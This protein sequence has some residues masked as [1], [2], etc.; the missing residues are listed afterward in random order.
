MAREPALEVTD[1]LGIRNQLSPI[2]DA[3]AIAAIQ[4][5]LESPRIFIAD[6]H[7]RYETALEY[8]RRRRAAEDD[9]AARGLTTTR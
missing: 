9:P 5:E 4:D 2:E 8:R 7:H 3:A 6:G 1:D